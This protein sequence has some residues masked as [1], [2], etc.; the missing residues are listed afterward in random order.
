MTA[1]VFTGVSSADTA[2]NCPERA[3]EY[4]LGYREW[5]NGGE[6]IDMGENSNFGVL[7]RELKQKKPSKT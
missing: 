1:I 6:I 3:Y 4:S 2:L 5:R 7:L